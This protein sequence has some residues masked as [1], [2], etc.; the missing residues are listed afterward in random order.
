MP[1]QQFKRS[2]RTRNPEKLNQRGKIFVRVF[3][4]DSVRKKGQAMK[5]N[6]T[7]S[8]SVSDATVLEVSEAIELAL[9]GE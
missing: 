9:F 4:E 2:V 3:M 7:R 6:V 8:I 5:G 1:K